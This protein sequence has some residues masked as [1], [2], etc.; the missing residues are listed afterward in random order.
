MRDHTCPPPSPPQCHPRVSR[1]LRRPAAG[2]SA[3]ICE[4][5]SRRPCAGWRGVGAWPSR[6]HRIDDTV[7][8]ILELRGANRKGPHLGWRA[9]RAT[10][11]A[12][13]G[14]DALVMAIWRRGRPRALLHHSDRG[15]QY[16]SESFQRLMA[17]HGARAPAHC[18]AA[19]YC[20]LKRRRTSPRS[21]N[22]PDRPQSRIRTFRSGS[23]TAVA[24]LW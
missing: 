22:Q 4:T 8:A 1:S 16:T 19:I 5:I 17:E 21:S 20:N 12:E 2:I 10:M 23:R 3:L 15:S 6:Q 18:G 13:L 11:T 24:T 14:T 9:L 7:R